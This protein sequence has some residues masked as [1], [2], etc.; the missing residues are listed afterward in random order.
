MVKC[1]LPVKAKSKLIN[2]LVNAAFILSAVIVIAT[3]CWRQ[4]HC[5]GSVQSEKESNMK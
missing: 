1:L 4:A 2:I 3:G 5:H